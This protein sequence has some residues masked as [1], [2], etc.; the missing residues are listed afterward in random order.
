MDPPTATDSIDTDLQVSCSPSSG[1]DFDENVVTPVTC[2]ATDDAMNSMTCSFIVIVGMY[3]SGMNLVFMVIA[4]RSYKIELMAAN[5][6]K[7]QNSLKI[8]VFFPL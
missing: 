8:S 6:E 3:L 1:S 4:Y 5:I 7:N 2:M